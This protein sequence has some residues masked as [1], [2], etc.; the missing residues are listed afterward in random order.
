MKAIIVKEYLRPSKLFV[1]KDEDVKKVKRNKNNK[2]NFDKDGTVDGFEF[3]G[4]IYADSKE[5][6]TWQEVEFTK[7]D[8]C[9]NFYGRGYDRVTAL[10]NNKEIELIESRYKGQSGYYTFE[11]ENA[12][13]V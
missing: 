8:S 4:Q 9:L 10:I 13:A 5:L 12:A 2:W 3:E 11:D 1:M 6:E 7:L